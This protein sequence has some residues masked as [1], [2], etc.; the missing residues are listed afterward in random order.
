MSLRKIF[1]PKSI[2]VVGASSKRGSV[3]Y[4]LFRNILKSQ[5]KGDVY[6]V[7]YKRKKVQGEKSYQKVSAISAKIDLAIIATPA[8]TVPAV[9]KDC[10]ESG[11]KGAV[12]ISAGFMESGKEGQKLG[13]EIE[14]LVEKYGIKIIGPN[15]LGF[16]HP[17]IGLNASF[18]SKSARKGKIAFISQSGALCTSILDW[19]EQAQVGFSH[20]V[21]IG[22]MLDV[23]FA[24]LLD[25]FGNDSETS[26]ILIYMESLRD[27]DKFL[28]VARRV[29]P[30]KPIIA[31]KVG[32]SEEGASAAKSHTGSLT[33]NDQVFDIA[34]RSVGIE[35]VLTITDLFNCAKT[36]SMKN[37]P[38]GK[39]LAIVTNAGGPG[40]ISTDTLIEQEGK[41]AKLSKA[42]IEKLNKV[43]PASWSHANPV[44]VLGDSTPERYR[45]A[46]EICM[47][48]K[49]IDAVFVLLTPQ[50]MTKP[51]VVAREIVK[52]NKT[53]D[54]AIIACWMG[55]AD[56]EH[57]VEILR[58]NNIPLFRNPENAIKSFMHIVRQKQKG[59]LAGRKVLSLTKNLKVK[60]SKNKA[61]I[62]S[63]RI[64]GRTV[65]LENE[66]RLFLSN[67]GINSPA[68]EVAKNL[69]EVVKIS[70]RISFPQVMKIVSPDILHKVDV[71][72]VILKIKTVT[73][74]QI[75]YK[76]ILKNIQAK[77]P[78]AKIEGVII[79]KMLVGG[80]ELLLGAK[81]D[82]IFGHVVAFGSGGSF[83]ELYQDVAF[84]LLPLNKQSINRLF[85]NTK[86]FKI[87][88]GY[89]GL[90]GT[91]LDKLAMTLVKFSKLIEDFPEVQEIDINPFIVD[92]KNG[93]VVDA[94]VIIQKPIKML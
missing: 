42:T 56:I 92:N 73:E 71:G 21:S 62:E 27:A 31:L 24:D 83:V 63:L 30:H 64:D 60:Y 68:N 86:I 51:A 17:S 5:Y 40:V 61:I 22:S 66:A 3:G 50:S 82:P 18:A 26:A 46:V 77:Q 11:V 19:A 48:D 34:F 41:I 16:L 80:Y 88:K 10:A 75:A 32:R 8:K 37:I 2:A 6:P 67:Y 85:D 49:G 94:K 70:K 57:G 43:L 7:N 65:M 72:G 45:I 14:D 29:S 78:N 28:K 79:E 12:I 53:S 55:G 84:E 89:R 90:P 35:R 93:Y 59:L 9:V 13:A 81:A 20:F 39:R 38:Q 47:R 69:D 52:I 58:K 1:K 4:D 54:K 91:D 74:A 44:D 36:L 25:Y 76:S 15:C 33:G 23:D 87:L